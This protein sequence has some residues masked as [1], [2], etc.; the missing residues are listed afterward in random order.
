[1]DN[2]WKKWP[3]NRY[4]GKNFKISLDQKIFSN[5]TLTH[6]VYWCLIA[7]T[8]LAKLRSTILFLCAMHSD[9][10]NGYYQLVDMHGPYCT[11]TT[12][13]NCSCS[14]LLYYLNIFF[15]FWMFITMTVFFLSWGA[16]K[17]KNLTR[18]PDLLLWFPNRTSVCKHPIGTKIKIAFFVFVLR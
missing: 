9:I 10:I 8:Y 16:S 15:S 5:L 14:F 11:R 17:I 13:W 18:T 2:Y 6:V 12:Y 7:P 1:M 4:K 3:L